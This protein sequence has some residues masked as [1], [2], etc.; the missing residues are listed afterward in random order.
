MSLDELIPYCNEQTDNLFTYYLKDNKCPAPLLQQA[1]AY[2]V[3]KGGKR[4]RPLLVYATGI[5]LGATLENLVLAAAAI[6]LIHSYSLIHDDL[7]AMDNADLRRGQPSCHKAYNEALA[8]LAGDALQPLAFQILASHPSSLSAQQRLA[9][10]KVLSEASGMNGMV[11]GQVLDMEKIHSYESLK[12]MYILKT[13]KLIYASI[14]LG[15]IASPSQNAHTDSILTSYAKN[16]GL[17]FQIQDD[18]LDLESNTETLGKPQGI[19]GTNQK[20]TFPSILG[21]KEA[22]K[23][24]EM[25]FNEA[26]HQLDSLGMKSKI[27]SE[28]TEYIIQRKK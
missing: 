3:N 24:V 26:E 2:S 16:I 28:L 9:M 13:G 15:L 12:E 4:L 6:E 21:V 18:L 19:D 14:Q 22:H 23:K 11:S 17:G 20:I 7:P 10:I 27:L 1:I 5:T 25:L 8:I